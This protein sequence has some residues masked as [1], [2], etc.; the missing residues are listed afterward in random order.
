MLQAELSKDGN[1]RGA[2]A[3]P[4]HTQEMLH[5]AKSFT[6]ISGWL[7]PGPEVSFYL[8]EKENL[9]CFDI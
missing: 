4:L 3:T 5:P 1:L 2:M 7:D 9:D 8:L 6:T